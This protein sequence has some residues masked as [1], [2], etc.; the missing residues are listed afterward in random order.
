MAIDKA[1]NVWVAWV[2]YQNEADEIL[3]RCLNQ[4]TW[5]EPMKVTEKPGDLFSSAVAVDGENRIWVAWSERDMAPIFGPRKNNWW[6]S[7]TV[8]SNGVPIET[9]SGWLHLYHAYNEEHVYH[10]GVCLLDLEDPTHVIARPREPLLQ[11][12]EI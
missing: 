8:G 10:L 1:G 12:E 5:S 4:G 2:S 3:L 9:E 6:D 11:P 7:T